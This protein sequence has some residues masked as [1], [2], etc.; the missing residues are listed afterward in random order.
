MHPLLYHIALPFVSLFAYSQCADTPDYFCPPLPPSSPRS[1]SAHVGVHAGSH[2][3]AAPSAKAGSKMRAAAHFQA[4]ASGKHPHGASAGSGSM[5]GSG[6]GY[7]SGKLV[8]VM[9]ASA[10]SK[11]VMGSNSFGAKSSKGQ[12]Y[13]HPSLAN[14][15]AQTASAPGALTMEA[16]AAHN[17][18]LEKSQS[19]QK[20]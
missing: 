2:F 18:A 7:G 10:P 14:N 4:G 19:E 16:L 13:Q 12:S 6:S 3:I 20:P 5:S 15:A 8:T 9:E 11:I 1:S 17:H